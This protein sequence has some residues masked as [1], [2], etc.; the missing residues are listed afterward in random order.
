MDPMIA[1]VLVVLGVAIGWIARGL[2]SKRR[3]AV[4]AFQHQT[5]AL[6]V[7]ADKLTEDELQ[8]FIAKFEAASMGN[9]Y[10]TLILPGAP[11]THRSLWLVFDLGGTDD[12]AS[13]YGAYSSEEKAK[14]AADACDPDG[15]GTWLCVEP[16][17][18]DALYKTG[19]EKYDS[20]NFFSYDKA[21]PDTDWDRVVVDAGADR[22]EID[23]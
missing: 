1:V 14:R 2:R 17:V 4:Y 8:S 23:P 6:K 7:R 12:E 18:V 20:P 10:R 15:H 11:E 19:L 21:D 3:D 22:L 13:L 16:I 5:P 9:A